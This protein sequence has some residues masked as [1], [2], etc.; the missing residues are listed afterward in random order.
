MIHIELTNQGFLNLKLVK[1][2]IESQS[3]LGLNSK[4]ILLAKIDDITAKLIIVHFAGDNRAHLLQPYNYIAMEYIKRK[5]KE[6]NGIII[7]DIETSDRY[8]IGGKRV[9]GEPRILIK[10]KH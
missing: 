6:C 9:N 4:L 3:V 2:E 8:I 10:K 1:N 7:Y 5:I